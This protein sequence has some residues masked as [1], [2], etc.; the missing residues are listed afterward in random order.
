MSTADQR[1]QNRP[2]TAPIVYF[3]SC[4]IKAALGAGFS[5]LTT[6][7]TPASVTSEYPIAVYQMAGET[8]QKY[9]AKNILIR[10]DQYVAWVGDDCDIENTVKFACGWS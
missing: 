7:Q 6:G 5:L 3:R 2:C 10:P 1:P 9:Q 8:A 4:G